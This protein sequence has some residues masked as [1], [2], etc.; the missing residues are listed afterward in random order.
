MY[1]S[2]FPLQSFADKIKE[3]LFRSVASVVAE[4][5]SKFR[6]IGNT[7]MLDE[8]QL[9]AAKGKKS[10]PEEK[11]ENAADH[12]FRQP[13]ESSSRQPGHGA[14]PEHAIACNIEYAPHRLAKG[15]EEN[16]IHV[17]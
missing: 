6:S 9:A 3:S 12:S 1:C 8:S 2:R 15:F 13:N 7:R 17:L 10:A 5:A 4:F 11:V 16:F 14:Q